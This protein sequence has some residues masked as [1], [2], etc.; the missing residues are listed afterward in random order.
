MSRARDR[1]YTSHTSA[2]APPPQP[3]EITHSAA[4]GRVARVTYAEPD[5]LRDPAFVQELR[6]LRQHAKPESGKMRGREWNTQGRRETVQ[7]RETAGRAYQYSGAAK[8]DDAPLLFSQVPVVDRL[9]RVV[10]AETGARYNFALVNYY[11][12]AGALGW[13]TDAERDLVQGAPIAGVSYSS[14]PKRFDLRAIDDHTQKWR[15]ELRNASVVT[16]RDACQELLQHCV[17]KQALPPNFWRV[18]VTF[19]QLRTN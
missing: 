10:E 2:A 1:T 9:R 13:H 12:D 16:M 15:L 18:S 6:R 14:A 8:R 19:R 3:H 4:D 5:E 17:P 11:S 7:I